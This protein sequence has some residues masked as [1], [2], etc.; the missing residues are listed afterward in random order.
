MKIDLIDYCIMGNR[1]K[2]NKVLQNIRTRAW[3]RENRKKSK[4]R[5]MRRKKIGIET[6]KN[7]TIPRKFRRNIVH[8]SSYDKKRTTYNKS[9]FIKR[10]LPVN[11]K[12]ITTKADSPLYL[13]SIKK[14]HYDSNGSIVIPEKFSIIDNP[15]DSIDVIRKTISALLIENVD[16]VIFNYAKC[17]DIDLGT[18]ALFD[19]ILKDYSEFKS[20]CARIQ[21]NKHDV[22]P[23]FGAININDENIQNLIWSVGS[24]ANLGIGEIQ[25][26][27]IENFKLR[28]YNN[29]KGKDECKR[30]E[31]KDL[32][33][34]EIADYVINSLRRMGK[35]LTPKKRDDLCTI[36]GEILINAEEH[37]TTN[38]RFSIGYFKEKNQEGSHM[39]L[40]RLVI[41]NFGDTIYE[42]FKSPDCPNK[43]FV[44]RM[45]ELSDKYTKRIFFIPGKFEEETLWTL[46]ALQEGVTSVSKES[47]K[48]GNGSIRFIES[49]FNIKGTSASDSISR[50]TILSGRT[51]ILFDGKYCITERQSR[52]GEIHKA[53][54]FNNT[55]NI[56]DK[57]DIECVMHTNNYFPGTL[58]SAELLL[59]DDDLKQI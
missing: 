6:R 46:Y 2:N 42:K 10:C 3:E 22:F 58:I 51:K 32:D 54:T 19:I 21:R 30:M 53:M 25:N 13:D 15:E 35:K 40:F 33:T 57:P 38:H 34:T 27:E 59:N 56:E 41:L 24:P 39:G 20:R 49:F 26:K 8:T 44:N 16:E 23:A 5:K 7:F 17:K 1:K 50:M 48:R 11:L 36:I 28:T 43:D 12:Y 47:Y 29:T 14:S 9:E 55:G 45:K 31:R 4:S 18:Q 37:S 52:N